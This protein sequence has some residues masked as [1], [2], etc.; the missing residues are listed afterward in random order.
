M[1]VCAAAFFQDGFGA[2]CSRTLIPGTAPPTQGRVMGA[3]PVSA[4][5]PDHIIEGAAR[6]ALRCT[7]A[8]LHL[9]QGLENN[10]EYVKVTAGNRRAIERILS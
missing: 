6:H 4:G 5:P 3:D 1:Q 2:N 9:T 10:F 8:A 7:E